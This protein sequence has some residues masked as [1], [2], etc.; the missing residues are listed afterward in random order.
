GGANEHQP[1]RGNGR[2]RAAASAGIPFTLGQLLRYPQ[3]RLPRD[4]G[5]VGIHRDQTGTRRFLAQQVHG[6]AAGVV[7]W[8]SERVEWPRTIE[9]RAIVRSI[10]A[11]RVEAV[12]DT[13]LLLLDPPDER[14]VVRVHVHIARTRIGGGS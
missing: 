2:T 3:R 11:P 1:A 6:A 14:R 8:S 13:W 4:V 12:F 9:C 10:R 7:D 5:S